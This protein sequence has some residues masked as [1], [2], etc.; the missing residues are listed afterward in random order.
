VSP[1]GHLRNA[2]A[3][4]RNASM[5][6]G[7]VG[8]AADSATVTE[9][10]VATMETVR[11]AGDTKL[12]RPVPI[13]S[14]RTRTSTGNVGPGATRTPRNRNRPG[15]YHARST[16]IGNPVR[17]VSTTSAARPIRRP[18]LRRYHAAPTTTATT[19]TATAP[20]TITRRRN[21]VRMGSHYQRSHSPQDP[22]LVNSAAG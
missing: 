6:P 11:P 20:G 18:S 7:P 9:V 17:L 1:P 12:M 21:S 5:P 22:L 4:L 10:D 8:G 3:R 16:V 13:S 14:S 2:R 15:R 19:T